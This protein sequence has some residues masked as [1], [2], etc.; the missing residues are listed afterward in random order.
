MAEGCEVRG[1]LCTA[2]GLR[3]TD[4][5]VADWDEVYGKTESYVSDDVLRLYEMKR[6]L[7]I[8]PWTS[9]MGR[10]WPLTTMM[11]NSRL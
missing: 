10:T 1:G 9:P 11:S 5:G 6:L 7:E 2:L 4:D 3:A 8:Y